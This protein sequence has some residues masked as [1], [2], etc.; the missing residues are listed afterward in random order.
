[1]LHLEYVRPDFE[2]FLCLGKFDSFYL[3]QQGQSY[4]Y[5]WGPLNEIYGR[6]E[7][8]NS[9]DSNGFSCCAVWKLIMGKWKI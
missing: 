4:K 1:M 2:L 7:R 9:S 6:L 3:D 8:R 5:H